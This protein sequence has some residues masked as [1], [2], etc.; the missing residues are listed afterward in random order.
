[1]RVPEE[2]GLGIAK[3][4]LSFAAWKEGQ[5]APGIGQVAV[6]ARNPVAAPKLE[7]PRPR[8]EAK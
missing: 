8:A 4:S 7:K 3:V 6:V 1:V 5:V 2:A